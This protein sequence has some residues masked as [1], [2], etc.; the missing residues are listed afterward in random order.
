MNRIQIEREDD[1]D[2]DAMFEIN[3]SPN[4]AVAS[5]VT[6]VSCDEHEHLLLTHL[7]ANC[8]CCHVVD[9]GGGEENKS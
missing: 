3:S 9:R 4:A 7:A 2:D 5:Y 1:D 8:H 6:R